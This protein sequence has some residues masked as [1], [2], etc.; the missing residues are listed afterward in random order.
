VLSADCFTQGF[1]RRSG[2]KLAVSWLCAHCASAA[3]P[4]VPDLTGGIPPR[5]PDALT[6][7]QFA[8]YIA[9]LD[10]HEREG[11]ILD[12]LLKGN[13]PGFL[14][15]LVPVILNA[16]TI[17]VMPEYLAIGSDSDFLRIPMSLPT[18]K[19]V[20]DRFRF[21]LPTKKIVDGIYN[22]SAYRF[23]PQPLPAGPEM[24]STKYYRLHNTMIDSQSR[25]RA[26]PQGVLIAGHKKDL[27]LT[28]R[29]MRIPGR[30][31]IYGWHRA[32]GMPIQPLS[33][34]HGANYADYSHGIRL[35]AGMA[36]MGG[37]PRSVDEVLRDPQLAMAL[38]DEG[39]INIAAVLA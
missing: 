12:Q 15:K 32:P 35:V 28:N 8:E 21:V 13:L 1:T 39:K 31:A 18:A 23:V 11:A 9:N 14:R 38:S 7:S 10:R 4:Q 5:S 6:G 33:T 16:A 17:F 25:S 37:V 22:Q 20:A 34:V 3:T 2:I 26:F 30:I 36:L 24:T 27:V 19:A 29:L